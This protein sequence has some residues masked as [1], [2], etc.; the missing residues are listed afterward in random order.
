M[1]N[2]RQCSN[3]LTDANWTAYR[4]NSNVYICSPCFNLNGREQ[5]KKKPTMRKV[6]E[7]NK[8]NCINCIVLLNSDN[9]NSDN[10]RNSYFMCKVCYNDK[11]NTLRKK[12]MN[13]TERLQKAY[14][15]KYTCKNC[16][17]ILDKNNWIK[18]RASLH[19]NICSPC[20]KTMGYIKRKTVKDEV[21]EA[22][23]GRCV[24]CGESEKVFLNIDHINNDGALDRL[25]SQ[26]FGTKMYRFLRR[27]GFPKD[28][29]QLLC[30]NC[31]WAKH[32]CDGECPHKKI[33]IDLLKLYI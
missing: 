9:W 14:E 33:N 20:F 4:R 21:I 10:K 16:N 5:Q 6:G 32:V 13:D 23:G 18:K 3:E 12:Y 2:C 1:K 30:C 24:C 11:K 19:D 26:L 22:Y 27:N 25:K 8:H 31:N 15:D 28:N 17:V 7:D 29:Y